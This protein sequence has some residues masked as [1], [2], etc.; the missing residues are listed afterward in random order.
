MFACQPTTF[1]K[2]LAVRAAVTVLPTPIHTEISGMERSVTVA[3]AIGAL[4]RNTT[5]RR[6]TYEIW[7]GN[8][9]SLE[10]M[11]CVSCTT[12]CTRSLDFDRSFCVPFYPLLKLKWAHNTF[13]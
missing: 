10:A 3:C 12:T 9:A 13:F 1:V 4:E 6:V 11:S 5:D 8:R 2:L 7:E